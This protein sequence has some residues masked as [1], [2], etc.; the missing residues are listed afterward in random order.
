M[1]ITDYP[2]HDW[3]PMVFLGLMGLSALIYVVLD[4]F[5]LG[6]GLLSPCVDDHDR[7][8]MIA[9]IGPFWDANETWLVLAVGL[10]LVA[11]PIAHGVILG[12]LY[13]PSLFMLV[14][15]ILRGV[16][17]EF[18]A[19][20][21]NSNKRQWD[22][23]FFAGSVM[24]SLSQGYMLGKYIIG[25]Q[26]GL[27]ASLFALLV[28]L[29]LTAAYGLIGACWLIA[30][31]ENDLQL[32]A[33]SWARRLLLGTSVGMLAISIATP[34]VS[35]RIFDAWFSFPN[36]IVLAPIP[37][38]SIALVIG[39]YYFL[40]SLPNDTDDHRWVPFC[41]TV[42]LFLMAFTGLAYSFFPYVVPEQY[43]VWEAAAARESL[44]IILVGTL[45]TLP[46]IVAYSIFAY[47]V[48]SGKATLLSYS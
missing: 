12:A 30:K 36:I 15:L 21:P 24:A 8:L 29:C 16:A 48:F 1:N 31:T 2:F 23:V 43:T 33:V 5:D 22:R 37:L 38:M 47:R 42:A 17:F 4:G 3:L 20:G 35:T 13:L 39:L 6:V 11:F 34:L 32:R 44:G 10:L 25:L 27:Y 46:M 45:V 7:S 26:T 14:G 9:S 28:A 40:R 18:R 19:K 41:L